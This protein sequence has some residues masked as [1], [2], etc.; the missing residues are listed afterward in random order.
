M[1]VFLL[2]VDHHLAY[3]SAAHIQSCHVTFFNREKRS[4]DVLLEMGNDSGVFR[5][6]LLRLSPSPEAGSVLEIKDMEAAQNP[7]YL[8][9]VTNIYNPETLFILAEF[10]EN[11]NVVAKRTASHFTVTP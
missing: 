2:T 8:R 6:Q 11:G 5:R 9:V 4:V 3:H 7:F 1:S 10:V